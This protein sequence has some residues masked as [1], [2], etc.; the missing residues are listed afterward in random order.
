MYQGAMHKSVLFKNKQSM[1]DI[2]S[3]APTADGCQDPQCHLRTC[4][5]GCAGRHH[6]KDSRGRSPRPRVFNLLHSGWRNL[7]N[8]RLASSR[9]RLG[10]FRICLLCGRAFHEFVA[11]GVRHFQSQ[12][13]L[14]GHKRSSHQEVKNGKTFSVTLCLKSLLLNADYQ[15]VKK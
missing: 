2:F 11:D 13:C 6:A 1:C 7:H 4:D 9:F 14:L 8:S 3:F 5:D 12:C 15:A 10:D